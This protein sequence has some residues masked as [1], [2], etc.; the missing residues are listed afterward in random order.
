MSKKKV[1]QIVV[2]A[3]EHFGV[4]R[5]YGVVGDTLNDVTDA[6]HH[7]SQ[8]EWVHVRHEEVGGFAA[9]AE[10]FMTKN[11]TACAG[12][13]GPGSLHFINGLF[14]SHRNGAPVVLIASQ[15]PTSVL[16]T[17]FPQEVD[18]KPIYQGCSVFCEEV[19][20]PQEAKRIVM[21]ACQAALTEKGV[22]VVILPSDISATEVEDL[23]IM[24]QYQPKSP[25][26]LPIESELL[27]MAEILNQGEKVGIY[28]GAGCEG[29]HAELIALA[30]KLKAPIAHTSRGK[31]FVEGHNPYN[32]GMTGMMGIKSGYEMIEHCD[33][34]II[35]GADFAWSQ[36]YPKHAKIIQVDIDAKKLGIR[37]AIE[38]GVIG[39]IKPT[40]TA[41][42]PHIKSKTSTVF[43]DKYVSLRE[44]CM[45]RLDQKAVADSEKLIHPQY[46]VELLNEYA[47]DDALATADG[48]SS[49]VWLL[50]HFQTNGKR[51]TLISLKHGTMANAMPQAI[52]LQKAY[53]HRQVISLSGDGGLTMLMGDLLTLVQEKLP[54]KVVIVNNGALDFVELEMKADG[55][56]NSYTDLHNPDFAKMADA[57][58]MKGFS[59]KGSHELEAAVK[60][61]LAHEGPAILD[62][63]TSRLE[64]I[65]PP[66]ATPSNFENMS[67]YAAKSMIG[68]EGGTFFEMLKDNF[69][70]K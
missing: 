59:A 48:G 21:S 6:M 44:K 54:V 69:L 52:G 22:A 38:L 47:D 53:P 67:L 68:G 45:A 56:V 32:V 17:N 2:E 28:A 7:H 24:Q 3:L 30:E 14:E 18:Y 9:G 16:G 11:L 25:L 20:N 43:L 27:K 50:R 39:Q 35:L 12:S 60:A 51:R 10:S 36:F 66:H 46:L 1:A 33:T 58:G 42:L 8:I 37:H 57:I 26:V 65:F 41:L 62:V 49:T 64:L 5:C 23:P 61:F 40:L 19:T 63:H 34:L 70:K 4:K 29:A 13:C 15:L 31:D 55:M